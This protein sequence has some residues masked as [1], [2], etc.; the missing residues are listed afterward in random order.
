MFAFF[1]RNYSKSAESISALMV[2]GVSGEPMM[3]RNSSSVSD[4]YA[5]VYHICLHFSSGTCVNPQMENL[6]CISVNLQNH[7]R[8]Y[9]AYEKSSIKKLKLFFLSTK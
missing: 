1:I 4:S 8:C 3:P 9:D 7:I 2:R 5:W 6:H